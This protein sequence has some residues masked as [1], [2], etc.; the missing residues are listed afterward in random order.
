MKYPKVYISDSDLQLFKEMFK[1]HHGE[2]VKCTCD[3]CSKER[4]CL[5]SWDLYNKGGVS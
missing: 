4:E 1:K 2:N 3:G 5:C